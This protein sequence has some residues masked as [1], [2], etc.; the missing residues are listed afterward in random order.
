MTL[1]YTEADIERARAAVR[2]AAAQAW[3]DRTEDEL[4]NHY[5]DAV[6]AVLAAAGRLAPA[7]DDDPHRAAG[8]RR[9]G[10]A[11]RRL[12]FA[13]DDDPRH[14]I[15]IRPKGWTIKHP[16]ACRHGDLFGCAVNLAAENLTDP[17]APLGRY[18]VTVDSID[19]QLRI[20]DRVDQPE[21]G[22]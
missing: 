7:A 14:I 15:D 8:H 3:S 18:A 4:L 11:A 19:G 21:A 2:A 10:P 1:P 16:L 20:G 22:R 12:A 13:A 17:P 6:V 9:R 5:A